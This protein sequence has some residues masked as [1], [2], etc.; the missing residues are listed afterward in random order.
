MLTVNQFDVI[1]KS[2]YKKKEITKD[3]LFL[4]KKR[5][6]LKILTKNIKY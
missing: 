3:D 2:K 6:I 1:L 5:H 4:R